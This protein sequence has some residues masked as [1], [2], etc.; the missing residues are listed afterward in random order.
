MKELSRLSP[1]PGSVTARK[2]V[3]RS[4]GSGLGKTSGRGHKGTGA[5]TGK[6][7]PPWFEGGQMPLQRRLP[8][9]GFTPLV[10]KEFAIVNTGALEIFPE[11][12]RVDP[13]TL[14]AAG[15]V[16]QVRDGVKILGSGDLTRRLDVV[17][18]AFSDTARKKIEAAGGTVTAILETKEETG[19]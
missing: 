3:G 6:G 13:A 16:R 18:H 17:A 1:Q 7:R 5:R 9:K 4:R 10:R 12:T 14:R 11:G 15:L 19:A 2:R 8:K